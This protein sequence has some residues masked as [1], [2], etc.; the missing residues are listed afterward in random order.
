MKLNQSIETTCCFSGHRTNK[1]P[2]GANEDDPRCMELRRKLRDVIEAVY[3]AG[4]R[5]FVC[6]MAQGSDLIFCEEVIDFRDYR[7]DVTIEAAIPCETQCKNWPEHTR[8]RYYRLVSQCDAETLLQTMYT[9]D[10][11]LRRN[12]YMV[13]KSS[14][15]IAVY[16]GTVGGTMQTVR[17]AK[18]QGLE[19]I[20]IAP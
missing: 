10:C 12:R 6:G 18:R 4:I 17:Y 20:T 11:M 13:D 14:V 3:K 16:D 8:N 7:T 19:I 5:H 9:S 15:L 1:L 2:W